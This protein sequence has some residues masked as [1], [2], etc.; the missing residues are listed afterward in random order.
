MRGARKA[1]LCLAETVMLIAPGEATC[2][3]PDAP[4]CANGY[5][6]FANHSEYRR[7]KVEMESY[8]SEIK[9]YLACQRREITIAIDE[10]NEAVDSFN[11]RVRGH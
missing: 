2:S 8:N 1:A 10:H 9:S 3:K 5:S 6:D 11:R 7:C 4:S